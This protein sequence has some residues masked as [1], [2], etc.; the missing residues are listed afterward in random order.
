M[1]GV[2]QSELATRYAVVKAA[3]RAGVTD[4]NEIRELARNA[5][6]DFS[7]SGQSMREV[8]KVVPF[9]NARTQALRNTLKAFAKTL[10]ASRVSNSLCLSIRR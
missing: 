9:L 3:K 5:T 2:S 8:N 7:V 1:D 6:I 4:P 10:Q